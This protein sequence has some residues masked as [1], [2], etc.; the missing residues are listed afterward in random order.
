MVANA[1]LLRNTVYNFRRMT[2]RRIQFALRAS[3][4]TPPQLAAKVPAMLG[5]IIKRRDKVRFD[6]AHLK[7]VD[8]NWIEYEIV[9]TMLDA[10][11]DLYMD[12]QQLINLEAMQMFADLGISMAPRPQHVLLQEAPD[13]RADVRGEEKAAANEYVD[14]APDT[15]GDDDT[16]DAVSRVLK[17]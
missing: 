14:G 10:N 3:P 11:Y 17:H 2:T 4:S 7:T 1:E 9:Y 13:T 8:Q 6:R 15:A 16:R 12:T 5:E